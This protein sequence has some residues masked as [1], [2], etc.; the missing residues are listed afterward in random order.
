MLKRTEI[1]SE[2]AGQ[3]IIHYHCIGLALVQ[4]T[5]ILLGS[6]QTFT[7]DYMSIKAF[8]FDLD[9]VITDTAHYHFL[10]WK[11]LASDL[12][13]N[14]TEIDNEALKGVDRMRSLEW[15][16]KKNQHNKSMDEKR[17][18]AE[19]KNQY[20]KRYINDLSPESV[21]PGV[22]PL[23]R[24]L[25]EM[26]IRIGLA[27]AS[28]NA[29]FVLDK[30][31]LTDYFDYIADANYIKNNKPDPE[32]FLN[33]AASFQLIPNDC[34]GIEDAITGVE[35]IKS[36]GMYAIG[37]GDPF[38]LARADVVLSSLSNFDLT[39]IFNLHAMHQAR[40]FV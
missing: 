39:Q 16:L 21:L 6:G 22:L 10:A 17:F 34:V 7:E 26:N 28:K 38:H 20:Y 37:V 2:F 33:V 27:S 8:I 12:Q 14:F 15:I 1:A 29:L 5:C 31:Q 4:Y 36:A 35:A 13:I 3:K 23:L 32:I 25:R 30:L 40:E 11:K 24:Q 9:G 19:T 18:L